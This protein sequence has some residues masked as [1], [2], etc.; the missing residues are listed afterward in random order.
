M[1]EKWVKVTSLDQ[2]KLGYIYKYDNMEG[3]CQLNPFYNLNC[4]DRN[5]NYTAY[6]KFNVKAGTDGFSPDY[7]FK[8]DLGLYIKEEKMRKY[9]KDGRIVEIFRLLEDGALVQD[10]LQPA[11]L[12]R[13]Y[14][15]YDEFL[16]DVI[17]FVP[18][19]D[20]F[21]NPLNL[22][23]HETVK[24]LKTELSNLT[25]KRNK[26]QIALNEDQQAYTKLIN[27]LKKHEA[28]ANIEAFLEGRITHIVFLNFWKPGIYE[29]NKN[30][31]DFRLISLFGSSDGNLDWRI[32]QY[33]DGSGLWETCI[34]CLSYEEALNIL[35]EF[36]I[37]KTKE[38]SKEKPKKFIIECAEEYG[39]EL[40]ESYIQEWRK[41]LKEN[42][43]RKKT[44]L[45]LE[46]QELNEEKN[47]EE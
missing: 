18:N 15:D 5:L 33:K 17:Y 47:E 43:E 37:E 9:L 25:E 35:H 32:N 42:K 3:I 28:L 36:L 1:T 12:E 24:S 4:E 23:I 19:E 46:L 11:Y 38:E 10:I 22:K 2:I 30:I 16:S 14:A 40:P 29:V 45:L 8:N 13:D 41:I 6:H 7:V 31:L 21:E 20:L 34:L 26:L 27:K 39:I 44:K